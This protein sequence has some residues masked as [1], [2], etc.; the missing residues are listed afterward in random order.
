MQTQK[1][2]KITPMMA[3]Y[4][5]I[6]NTYPDYLLFYRMGDFYELFF[7]DALCASKALDIT[8]TKRG[9]N[10]GKE[11]PMCGVPFHAYESYLA[12]LVKQGYKIAICEQVEKPKEAKKRG[13]NA[14]VKREVVRLVTAGTLTEDT[15][16]ES[17]R[18]NYLLC[19]VEDGQKIG[20]SWVD[21]STGDFL[22]QLVEKNAF[23]TTLVQLNPSEII[24]SE[25]AQ[26]CKNLKN[27]ILEYKNIITFLPCARFSYLNM[28]E[29]MEKFF[30]I[31]L[32]D[33]FGSFTRS[34]ISA[35]GALIDYLLLTQKGKFPNLKKP[36]QV[37]QEQFMSIDASTRNG[38]ELFHSNTQK[39]G[40]GL[41]SII[42]KTVTNA[43]AR[44]LGDFLSAPLKNAFEINQRLMGV[45]FFYKQTDI[46]LKIREKLKTLSDM[47]RALARLS[48]GRGGP[49]DLA[50]IRDSLMILPSVNGLFVHSILPDILKI[51]KD[52]L[53]IYDDL[54]DDLFRALKPEL[55]V[56]IREGGFI[57]SGYFQKLD[58]LRYTKEHSRKLLADLTE[59]YICATGINS[60]KIVYNNLLG[61]FIEVP[62]KY[63]SQLLNKDPFI[64]RQTTANT[65]RFT[66]RELNQLDDDLRNA[67]E[68]AIELEME[69]FNT[70]V[71]KIISRI[72]DLHKTSE[73]LAFF[74]V[75]SALGELAVD[76]NYCLPIVDNST[77]FNIQQG[78]HPVVEKSLQEQHISFISNDCVLKDAERLWLLT[79]PNMAGKSTFL[80]QNAI[81]AIMAQMGSFVPALSAHI[82]VID[83]VFSRVGASD[84]LAR[85]QSTFMVEMVETATI[86]NQAT[87]HSL[88]IL[89]EIGR[90]TATFDGL[91]IAWAVVEYL[92]DQCQCRTLFATHYHELTALKKQLSNMA[93]YTMAI[94]E[95]QGDVVFLH[96]VEVGAVDKS[97]GIHVGKLAGL[98]LVVIK[99]AEMI[100]KILEK[101]K[102][103]SKKLA[104]DL[105]LFSSALKEPEKTPLEK[106][107]AFINPDLMTPK[108]ALDVL[109]RLKESLKN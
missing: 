30:S 12:R 106:E 57:A 25:E 76:E 84:D 8:L 53:S 71:Q 43:G 74:D 102:S 98:P 32:L 48:I 29:R 40:K 58:D 67:S 28:K 109:Y 60:L 5:E 91:S 51:Y 49:K 62:S 50:T 45:E 81:I 95:W 86:L 46:R 70:F 108:E 97:Y 9:K 41:F 23:F 99:R 2:T 100:L 73:A 47:D 42:N 18:H 4:F 36:H 89:D 88:V 68:K 1:Q 107:F 55:P 17:S 103:G 61:Y 96:S 16:L 82:G 7:D 20:L 35:A 85:G 78:R 26:N 105:P 80:R 10:E 66:T 92:H 13:A 77:I 44:L 39:N 69:I 24:M 64:H 101:E 104:D 52:N 75:M 90:G 79:G 21:I 27:I 83:K 15:L 65:I 22:T 33:S 37:V 19:A 11:I 59:N 56:L 93:L 63:A 94:K 3:Q 6:K 72:D 14:L 34:E 87:E 31:N 38:L 54:A